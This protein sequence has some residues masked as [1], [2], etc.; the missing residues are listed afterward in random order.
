MPGA[1]KLH[2]W[3][4]AYP[5]LCGKF[6]NFCHFHTGG[7]FLLPQRVNLECHRA[8]A[9]PFTVRLFQSGFGQISLCDGTRV[10]GHFCEGT[11]HGPALFH[12][13]RG[14]RIS[15]SFWS[16]VEEEQGAAFTKGTNHIRTTD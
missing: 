11:L 4:L 2:H 12:A 15:G 6:L 5:L 14:R 13:D 8:V 16:G 1:F 9:P 7:Q 3:H 10:V